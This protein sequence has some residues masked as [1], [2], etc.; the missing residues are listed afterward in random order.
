MLSMTWRTWPTLI[1]ICGGSGGMTRTSGCV[2]TKTRVSFLSVS[3]SPS[4]AS[5]A[6]SQ[7]ALR[8]S[9]W[10]MRTQLEQRPQKSASSALPAGGARQFIALAAICA[11]VYLPAPRGPAM[12]TACGKRSRA[13]ISRSRVIVAALPW[14]SEK[15]ISALRSSA[16]ARRRPQQALADN[17]QDLFAHRVGLLARV[18]HHHALRLAL[19]DLEI[20]P[21]HALEE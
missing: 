3:L 1:I 20:F 12:I 6:S 13:I 16:Y 18:D 14:K 10:A 5:M 17:V 4:R 9:D 7:R 11:S 2:C 8:S 19:G 15:P 21:T